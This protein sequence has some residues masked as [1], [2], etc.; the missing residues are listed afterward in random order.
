MASYQCLGNLHFL[1]AVARMK[2]TVS[3]KGQIVLPVDLRNQDHIEPGQEFAIERVES[4]EYLIKRL[5]SG[6][7]S[8]LVG[9]QRQTLAG[10][11]RDWMSW[12]NSLMR[13]H[14]S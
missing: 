11:T 13:F 4:G 10:E 5:P 12:K 1:G 9:W 7:A 14:L 3:S 8:G 6:D 2:T